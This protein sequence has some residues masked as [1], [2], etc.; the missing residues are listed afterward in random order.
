MGIFTLIFIVT[1]A[2]AVFASL[3]TANSNYLDTNINGGLD[4]MNHLGLKIEMASDIR[5]QVNDLLIPKLSIP[6]RLSIINAEI[7]RSNNRSFT[8]TDVSP[9][10]SNPVSS[11]AAGSSNS[12]SSSRE[13]LTI[14]TPREI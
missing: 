13:K 8:T 3:F 11:S 9:T 10:V 4:I 14:S 1:V 7:K 5:K 6:T 2:A 12:I